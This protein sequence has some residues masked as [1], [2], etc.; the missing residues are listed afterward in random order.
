M[1]KLN[2]RERAPISVPRSG[3]MAGAISGKYVVA[4]GSF[5]VGKQKHWTSEVEAFDP[6]SNTWTKWRPLPE[7]R[8][9]AASVVFDHA[10]Y[11]FGGIIDGHARGDAWELRNQEWKAV[12][13][14]ELPEHRFYAAAVACRG[15]I[16]LV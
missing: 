2:W 1:G 15:L 12:H 10:L 14:A 4:G 11:F 5:W 6:V 8:S 9:D 16:Y 3:F 13:G 7:P